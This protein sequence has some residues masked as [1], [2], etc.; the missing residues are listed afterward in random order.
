MQFSSLD[1]SYLS[2]INSC[3]IYLTVVNAINAETEKK[4]RFHINRKF[5]KNNIIYI[6][7]QCEI[8]WLQRGGKK[9]NE[10]N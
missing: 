7:T 2:F 8:E 1:K 5:P 4:N 10:K 3:S 6:R 9:L